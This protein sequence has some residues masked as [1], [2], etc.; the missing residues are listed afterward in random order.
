MYERTLLAVL[1]V[2]VVGVAV[3]VQASTPRGLIAPPDRPYRSYGDASVH[4][5][6]PS[7]P[8]YATG[9]DGVR[10][11]L[12]RPARRIVS[13]Y[14]STDEYL[15]AIVPPER[16]VGVSDTAYSAASSNVLDI[17]RRYHPVVADTA[18]DVLRADPDLVLTP[19]SAQ[20]EMPGLLRQAGLP[21]YRMYTQ[22]ETLQS[23]EDRI[24]LVGYLTGEDARADEVR[25]QFAATIARAAARKPA[26][27]PAPRVLGMGGSYTYGRGTLFDDILRVLG[28]E[29]IAATQ[30]FVG[31]DRVTDE[32]IV[33]WNPDWIVAGADRGQ[34]DAV[35]QQ[36]MQR[37]AIASTSAGQHGRIVVIE[38]DVFLPLS[39]LAARLVERL[40]DTFYGSGAH[41]G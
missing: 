10:V 23:I 13:Q 15:Y 20:W 37:P 25:R 12:D 9:S 16:I 2:T 6:G 17:V 41:G 28:A 38:N 7:Y 31:Y 5:E 14:W 27:A 34:V 18:E 19:D 8:R 21:V 35:R 24:R 11:R 3:W 22:F 39:P 4:I 32:H 33:R 26:G 30:G 29:N 1:G 40:A 36:L